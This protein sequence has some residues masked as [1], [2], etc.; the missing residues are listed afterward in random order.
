MKWLPLLWTALRRKP[1]RS[2]FTLLS[3]VV[4]FLLVGIMSG[5]NAAFAERIENARIDR[6][7]VT[8]RY[9]AWF[10][11]AYLDQIGRLD[12]VT[13][14]VPSAYIEASYQEP[15]NRLFIEMTDA[16]ILAVQPEMNLSSDILDE[17]ERVQD[18]IILS[19]GLADRLRVTVGDRVPFETDRVYQD[20]SRTW[21]FN[22]LA[23]VPDDARSPGG[24]SI[25]NFRYLS[26]GRADKNRQYDIHEIDLLIDDPERAG[27][28]AGAIE[29]LFANSG[30]PV[31]A[32]P[33]RTRIENNLRGVIDMQFFTYAFSA[34]SLFMILFLAG[35]VMAQS[36]RERIPEFGVMKAVG[37][38]DAAVSALIV[39]E[40][41]VLCLV[42][43]GLGLALANAVPTLAGA[44]LPNAPVPVITPR[45]IGFTVGAAVLVAIASAA[46]AVWR[47]K[48]LTIADALAGR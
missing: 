12:G 35:N 3:I 41:I 42:G 11:I 34:A 26:E 33:E 31:I 46:P 47:V 6:I 36:V 25:G 32:T 37:F 38:S 17:L 20:G 27:A 43:A 29:A 18:G 21:T 1:A 8:A 28:T 13:H 2:I 19:R 16:R 15:T 40:I 39:L 7:V 5:L 30:T 24:F 10:P 23:T 48:R 14:I 22:V 45:V 44:I 4:A 9:G